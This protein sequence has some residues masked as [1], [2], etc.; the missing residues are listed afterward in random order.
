MITRMSP[1]RLADR[2]GAPITL[3]DRAGPRQLGYR[4]LPATLTAW[5]SAVPGAVDAMP[6]DCRMP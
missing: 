4:G 5:I 6:A 3:S 1:D 2:P